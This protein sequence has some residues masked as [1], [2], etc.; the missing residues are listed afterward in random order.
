MS[1][2]FVY[3]L[4]L[5]LACAAVFGTLVSLPTN[6]RKSMRIAWTVAGLLAL[7]TLVF[8]FGET[9]YRYI[10]LGPALRAGFAGTVAGF[11]AGA[12]IYHRIR[13]DKEHSWLW[14]LACLP[15]SCAA[16]AATVMGAIH[17]A[18]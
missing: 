1:G 9:D 15:I 16:A 4:G 14:R 3:I 13:R 11:A 7:L 8:A 12:A 18:N 5:L 6:D 17:L 2:E 10:D